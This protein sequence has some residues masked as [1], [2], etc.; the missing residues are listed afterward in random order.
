MKYL[1]LHR[2]L[3]Q[4]EQPLGSLIHAAFVILI[5]LLICLETITS[6]FA[7]DWCQFSQDRKEKLSQIWRSS[8]DSR[9]Q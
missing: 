1:L 3:S 6:L 2:E 8:S 7:K 5:A 9:Y 4:I